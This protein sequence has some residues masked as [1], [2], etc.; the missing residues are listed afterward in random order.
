MVSVEYSNVRRVL[1]K[2]IPLSGFLQNVLGFYR[3]GEN[4]T[5]LEMRG[6]TS[7]YYGTSIVQDCESV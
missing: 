7:A 4:D 3:S 6:M 1:T 5:S 2:G